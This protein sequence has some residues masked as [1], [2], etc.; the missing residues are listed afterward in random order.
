MMVWGGNNATTYFGNG[1]RTPRTRTGGG[2]SPPANAPAGRRVTTPPCGRARSWSCGAGATVTPLVCNTPLDSGGQFSL[3]SNAWTPTSETNSPSCPLGHEAVWTGSLMIVWGGGTSGDPYSAADT[4]L[5]SDTWSPT[6]A[7]RTASAREFPLRRV[8]RRRDDRVG[9]ARTGSSGP[10]TPA[11]GTRPPPT[12]WQATASAGT[13]LERFF[14][15]AV[16]TGTR[17]IVWGGQDGSTVFTERWPVRP[18]HRL[19]AVTSG[20]GGR[21]WPG[22]N[23]TAVWPGSQMVVWGGTGNNG[24]HETRGGRY[25]PVAN[26]WTSHRDGRS[27]ARPVP[28]HTAVWTGTRDDRVGRPDQHRLH[29]TP[30][31]ATTPWPMPGLTSHC[32]RRPGAGTRTPWCGPARTMI[33]WGGAM[34][35]LP[36]GCTLFRTGGRITTQLADSWTPTSLTERPRGGGSSSPRLDRLGPGR[37]GR[38]ARTTPRAWSAP[39]RRRVRSRPRTPGWPRRWSARRARAGKLSGVCGPGPSRHRVGRATDDSGTFTMVGGGRDTHR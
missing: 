14:H 29:R 11:P 31:G 1:F 36:Q 25:D 12:T 27:P 10:R 7:A 37:V 35:R 38:R 24:L 18:R 5:R 26:A 32:R 6:N 30:A 9:A 21:R 23:H 39:H 8:D 13:P 4:T 33:V 16:W 22:R 19:M 34:P 17:M 15:T 28:L 20:T 3:A 2:R